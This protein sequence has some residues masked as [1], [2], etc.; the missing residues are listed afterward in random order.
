MFTTDI[1]ARIKYEIKHVTCGGIR[2]GGTSENP[3]NFYFYVVSTII[4]F[5]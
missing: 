5:S 3:V 1:T 2:V 4:N